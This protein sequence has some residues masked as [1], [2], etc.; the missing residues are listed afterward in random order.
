MSVYRFYR[1]DASGRISHPPAEIEC[2]GDADA[3]AR[4]NDLL[5][6]G[7][8]PHTIEIWCGSRFVTQDGAPAMP[9]PASCA[10]SAARGQRTA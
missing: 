5:R 7:W 2:P 6:A 10:S 3:I 4:S 9:S 8:A 1:I